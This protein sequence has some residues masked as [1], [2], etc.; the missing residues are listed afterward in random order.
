MRDYM[1]ETDF[2]AVQPGDKLRLIF[3]D[4]WDPGVKIKYKACNGLVTV[5]ARDDTI[6]RLREM[7]GWWTHR[8]FRG[9]ADY[10][11]VPASDEEM[12]DFLGI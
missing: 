9:M 1:S 7:T 6:V 4:D 5:E 10:G 11:I 12:S 3:R 2:A 8:A